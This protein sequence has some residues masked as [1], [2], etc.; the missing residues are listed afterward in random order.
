MIR[1]QVRLLVVVALAFL[2][3]AAR[4]AQEPVPPP[5]LA[6]VISVDQLRADYLD[7][8]RPLF[9]GAFKRFLDE[10][11][12]FENCFLDYSCTETGPGH[13]T[14]ATGRNP[15]SHGIVG[16]HWYSR[17]WRKPIYCVEDDA[18]KPVGGGNGGSPKNLRSD[19]L[20]D[21]VRKKFPAAKV[22]SI[23]GKDRAAI[24]LGGQKPHA[25]LWWSES[26]ANF[27][28]SS[29]YA[30]ELPGWV[31]SW[32]KTGGAK[33]F[34]G[35]KWER[36]FP[37]EEY[38]RCGASD[39][40]VAG[41]WLPAFSKNRFPY[42]FHAKQLGK[43]IYSSP[44]I[45]D[46][47]LSLARTAVVAE[48]LGKDAEPDLLCLSFSGLDIVGHGCGPESQEAADTLMRLDKALGD[49]L[50]F[51]EQRVGIGNLVVALSAD[52]G[53]QSLPE[54]CEKN[55]KPGRRAGKEAAAAI[56]ALKEHLEEKYGENSLLLDID[57]QGAI[58][59]PDLCRRKQLDFE[60]VVGEVAGFVAKLD[61]VERAYRVA[62]VRRPA[63]GD[64]LAH[65][66]FNVF[67]A[68]RSPDVFFVGKEGVY[69]SSTATGTGHGTPWAYDRSIPLL[70]W[71]G[72]I[73]VGR[74]NDPTQSLDLA[75]T[76]AELL[77]V[78]APKDLPG[79]SLKPLFPR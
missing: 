23:S 36:I 26:S 27:V 42:E 25:A 50:T 52:H 62:Q 74:K 13:A 79:K 18:T 22:V 33:T 28:T 35:K 24:L 73:V 7:R 10:G 56:K 29:Y 4:G 34:A 60:E 32:E 67:D 2:G 54:W 61:F 11:L 38:R 45:D 64:A 6:L 41:E 31:K 59:D 16:N 71:G 75:P 66:L 17:Q 19:T 3:G 65:F 37:P 51:L 8:F 58:V 48:G 14:I 63:A 21:W 49:F 55:G 30:A 47:C 69:T 53:V 40:D 39:D 43:Q 77:G 76:M 1:N 44:M 9:R 72:D 68:E 5:K 78:S 70:F 46:L 20:A 15:R 12:L 57:Y